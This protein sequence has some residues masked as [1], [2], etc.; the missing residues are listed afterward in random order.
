MKN[1]VRLNIRKETT[2]KVSEDNSLVNIRLTQRQKEL[3][4]AFANLL[5]HFQILVQRLT[6]IETFL[7]NFHSGGSGESVPGGVPEEM[8]QE[9]RENMDEM[10]QRTV[11]HEKVSTSSLEYIQESGSEKGDGFIEVDNE[12]YH[13][14][15]SNCPTE[16]VTP[17]TIRNLD[18][19]WSDDAENGQR[20][21]L[22][23]VTMKPGWQTVVGLYKINANSLEDLLSMTKKMDRDFKKKKE[24]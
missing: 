18:S 4:F 22:F 2:D 17:E 9:V 8:P 7:H 5:E 13:I 6:N 14:Y 3:E 24:E 21:G 15:W 19:D 16:E 10:V 12:T 11:H 20:A 23:G 1:K